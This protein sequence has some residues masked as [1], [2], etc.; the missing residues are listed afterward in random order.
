MQGMKQKSINFAYCS[1]KI[2]WIELRIK[3]SWACNEMN[4]TAILVSNQR[5]PCC[6]GCNA[7]IKNRIKITHKHYSLYL[8]H[9]SRYMICLGTFK[10]L[11]NCS[12]DR[13]TNKHVYFYEIAIQWSKSTVKSVFLIIVIQFI[14]GHYSFICHD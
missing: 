12:S 14:F 8:Y 6:M 9:I 13:K 5:L 10:Y 4:T 7:S 1:D 3:E 11:P 2:H